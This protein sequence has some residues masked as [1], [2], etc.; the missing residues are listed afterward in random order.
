MNRVSLTQSVDSTDSLLH[1]HRVPGHVVVH[2]R[3]AELEV[4]ALGGRL[5]AE[6]DI[7]FTLSESPLRLVAADRPPES[8]SVRHL[9]A[10]PGKAHQPQGSVFAELFPQE[11]DGVGVLSEH[12]DLAGFPALPPQVAQNPLQL[13]ELA[14]GRKS[15]RHLHQSANV[16]HFLKP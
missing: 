7:G 10:P 4:Q 13:P 6:Q 12:H 11:V 2:E 15:L 3:A 5:G 9:A 1:S 16:A 8:A 14:V